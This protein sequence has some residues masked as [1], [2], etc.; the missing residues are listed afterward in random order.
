MFRFIIIF[1]VTL[2]IGCG[3]PPSQHQLTILPY[4]Q[5][6]PI[7]CN[8]VLNIQGQRW[9]IRDFSLYL[10]QLK[11]F[12]SSGAWS[13]VTLDVDEDSSSN[14][15]LLTP[16]CSEARLGYQWKINVVEAVDQWQK[17]K[18][19]LGVP[20]ELN[21]QNPIFQK[22]PL[23]DPSMFWVWRT[24]HKFL[25]LEMDSEQNSFVFHLGSVG[26]QSKS[27]VRAPTSACLYSN[28]NQYEI[29]L[30]EHKTIVLDLAVLMGGVTLSNNITCKSSPENPDCLQLLDNLSNQNV[31]VNKGS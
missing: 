7:D 25:R 15:V 26:C 5:G 16:N 9:S 17:V 12:D 20:F 1:L 2:L 6:K 11:Y 8:T 21:H 13:N 30:A 29:D 19:T 14:V 24:G 28:L 23:N 22:N 27:A 18:F 10:S 4:W 31:F 3:K